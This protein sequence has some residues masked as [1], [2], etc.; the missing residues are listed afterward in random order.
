M[1]PYSGRCS[2][3]FAR[4]GS[5]RHLKRDYYDPEPY[6]WY[7]WWDWRPYYPWITGD[8]GDYPPYTMRRGFPGFVI[9]RPY[10]KSRRVHALPP[11]QVPLRKGGE[12]S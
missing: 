3:E 8:T 12:M 1:C 9:E 6:D 10:P 7:K 5:C 4:C 11:P 2:S